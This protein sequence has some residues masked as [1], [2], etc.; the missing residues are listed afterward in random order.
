MGEF[1]E[2]RIRVLLLTP[3]AEQT[4]SSIGVDLALVGVKTLGRS[5]HALVPGV[6]GS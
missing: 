1:L 3:G 5:I 4:I 2:V 6:I